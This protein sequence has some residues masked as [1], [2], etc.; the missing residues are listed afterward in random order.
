MPFDAATE[1]LIHNAIAGHVR[2]A[3]RSVTFANEEPRILLVISVTHWAEIHRSDLWDS[4]FWNNGNIVEAPP[5]DRF[6]AARGLTHTGQ[7]V[8]V[9]LGVRFEPASVEALKPVRPLVGAWQ[10]AP[11]PSP[12]P[13]PRALTL[14]PGEMYLKDYVEMRFAEHAARQSATQKQRGP[15]PKAFWAPMMAEIEAHISSGQL[16]ASR[17]ADIEHAMNRWLDEHE[18]EA[19]EATVRRY[20]NRVWKKV[21]NEGS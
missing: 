17:L 11:E 6:F 19:G 15:K 10:V 3:A 7:P 2:A 4:Q 12:R 20:A 14:A 5:E 21:Q 9:T 1:T 16:R 13:L 8:C 18:E